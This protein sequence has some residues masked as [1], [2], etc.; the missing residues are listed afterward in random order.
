KENGFSL[1][2]KEGNDYLSEF[3]KLM[4]KEIDVMILDESYRSIIDEK[5]KKSDKTKIIYETS[6]SKNVE[7]QARNVK[8]GTAFNIFISGID[9][10]GPVTTTARSD[11]NLL[12]TVNPKS[13]KILL[14][15]IPRDTYTRIAGDGNNQFDKLTHSGIYGIE[16]TIRTVENLLNTQI[17]YYVRV[18][19]DSFVHIIDAI[20]GVSV[21][22]NQYFISRYRGF[23]FDE[24]EVNLDGEKALAFVRERY[25]LE[26]GDTSRRENQEKVLK[27][28]INKALSPS[29]LSNYSKIMKTIE[30]D[31]QTNMPS[32]KIVELVN[33]QLE[34]SNSW[35]IN[36]VT[37]DGEGYVGLSSYAMPYSQLYMYK[38][39]DDDLKMKRDLIYNTLIEN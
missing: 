13:H 22:N 36:S 19:F 25:S 33:G 31:I 29:I 18:N 7:F 1:K 2:T 34:F 16:S 24:G 6:V 17:N 14:T 11:V 10:K 32:E 39:D 5:N 15:S 38:L 37:I 23:E 3:K 12:M 35:Q 26:K 4:S 9:T 30:N 28:M 21:E 27:A 8:E 20:G